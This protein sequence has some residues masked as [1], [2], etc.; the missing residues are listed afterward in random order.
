MKVVKY[1]LINRSFGVK[2]G[3]CFCALT[4]IGAA[5]LG[6]MSMQDDLEWYWMA[7]FGGLVVGMMG[8]MG[9]IIKR[10]RELR[11]DL[12]IHI[13]ESDI[14]ISRKPAIF[15]GM[16]NLSDI[17]L[18]RN[19]VRRFYYKER[20]MRG[21]RGPTRVYHELMADIFNEMGCMEELIIMSYL[22]K[23]DVND[24]LV[25][26]LNEILYMETG[27]KNGVTESMSTVQSPDPL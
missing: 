27:H 22:P 6:L 17:R 25:K 10:T 5:S 8:W 18:R 4:G 16:C 1:D 23:E 2:L 9:V 19:H 14:I 12:V 20:I 26:S 3:M 13:N 15:V 21:G 7:S 24:D 11:C